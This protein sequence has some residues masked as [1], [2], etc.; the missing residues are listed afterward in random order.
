M[1]A[2][3]SSVDSLYD[4]NSRHN[5][6]KLELT[7]KEIKDKIAKIEVGLV[8]VTLRK[9][10]YSIGLEPAP[11]DLDRDSPHL[12]FCDEGFSNKYESE[13]LQSEAWESY[14]IC[15]EVFEGPIHSA[16]GTVEGTEASGR[17]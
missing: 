4:H 8:Q 16:V 1:S 17:I 3:N 5:G 15:N 10:L 11:K 2:D 9:C 12:S 7:D 13:N 14:E 6:Y